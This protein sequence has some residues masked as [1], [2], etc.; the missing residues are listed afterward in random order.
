MKL[1]L[2]LCVVAASA[3]FDAIVKHVNHPNTNATWTARTPVRS[4]EDFKAMC[5]TFM[6]GHPKYVEL[7]L[8]EYGEDLSATFD[9]SLDWR[10]KAPQC[11]VISKIRDQ[12]S[13]GSCW[14][15]GS[16]ETAAVAV[17]VATTVS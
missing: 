7:N 8:P 6:P 4:M 14:A 1:A 17:M 2:A 16:T 13:C 12:S 9:D 11:T 15:F 3:D 5:G 10:T